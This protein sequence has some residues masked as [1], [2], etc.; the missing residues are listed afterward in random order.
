MMKNDK[1]NKN[2]LEQID[3]QKKIIEELT[4]KIK[5]LEDK[6]YLLENQNQN[7]KKEYLK[8]DYINDFNC[9]KICDKC[10]KLFLFTE[11]NCCS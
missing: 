9:I 10:G 7:I 4:A 11:V 2:L 3:I 8:N 1:R 5:V 6:I